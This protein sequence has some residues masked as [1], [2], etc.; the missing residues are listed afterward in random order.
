M[1]IISIEGLPGTKKQLILSALRN[2]LKKAI[3]PSFDPEWHQ[4]FLA[5][6]NKFAFSYELNRLITLHHQYEDTIPI[7]ESAH[8]L[9]KVYVDFFVQKG[10]IDQKEYEV[11][12]KYYHEL[13]QQPDVIIY[14]Y[15]TF[16][17]VYENSK[18][19]ALT[20]SLHLYSEN[21]F[22]ALYYRYEW[23]F[24]T[25]NC[26]IPIFKVNIDDDLEMIL[27]NIEE[28]FDKIDKKFPKNK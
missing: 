4:N 20:N 19:N 9:K 6:P 12:M 1:P 5:N 22:K 26:L 15:G 27:R 24:D 21:D 16:E 28:I 23:V 10:Y 17:P 2:K 25:N 3:H 8:A 11:F 14:F 13:Y 7:F 18:Q